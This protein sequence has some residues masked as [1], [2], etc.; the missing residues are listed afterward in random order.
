MLS[1]GSSSRS[2]PSDTSGSPAG[3]SNSATTSVPDRNFQGLRQ[4]K[5][6]F[7]PEWS[8]SYVAIPSLMNLPAVLAAVAALV[9]GGLSGV[10]KK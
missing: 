6:K 7:A 2:L 9:S 10:V 5:E 1:R 4:Y 3:F 8:P